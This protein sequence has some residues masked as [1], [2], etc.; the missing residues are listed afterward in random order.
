MSQNRV[1]SAGNNV[2]VFLG[3]SRRFSI[4]KL[5]GNFDETGSIKTLDNKEIHEYSEK[6]SI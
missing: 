5:K 6:R 1:D 2:L 4:D 3:L